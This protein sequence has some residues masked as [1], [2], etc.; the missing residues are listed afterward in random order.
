[1][2]RVVDADEFAKLVASSPYEV[3]IEVK[4]RYFMAIAY[5]EQVKELHAT[6]QELDNNI[7]LIHD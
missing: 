3:F 1:M 6:A 2:T 5:T 7:R 4:L